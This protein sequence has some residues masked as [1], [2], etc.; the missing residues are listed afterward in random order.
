[1]KQQRQRRDQ[2]SQG[3]L[4]DSLP[5]AALAGHAVG[6]VLQQSGAQASQDN[7]GSVA[8]E[9]NDFDNQRVSS[10]MQLTAGQVR[11]FHVVFSIIH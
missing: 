10:Q 8:I 3:P 5:S 4:A 1:M 11:V 7:S 6:S 2:F 9:I